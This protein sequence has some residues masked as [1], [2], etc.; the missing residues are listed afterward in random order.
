MGRPSPALIVALLA[1]FVALGGTTY[2]AVQIHGSQIVDNTIATSKLRNGA[3]AGAK[4]RNGAVTGAKLAPGLRA[5][6]L[7]R[8]VTGAQGATGAKGEAGATGPQGL[9]GATGPQGPAG[10]TG[11]KGEPGAQ[12]PQGVVGPRGPGSERRLVRTGI[13]NPQSIP[14][15]QCK[16][17]GALRRSF[18]MEDCAFGR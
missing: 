4:L 18:K 15:G 14:A 16:S 7:Q 3:V 13:D 10:A 11:A 5:R 8:S 12:G 17:T 9:A 2:A 6:L 1:L